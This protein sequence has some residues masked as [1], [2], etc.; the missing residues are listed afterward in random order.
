MLQPLSDAFG[1]VLMSNNAKAVCK[2]LLQFK[3]A[4][5]HSLFSL[6]PS[7]FFGILGGVVMMLFVI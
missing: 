5:T 7:P 4:N 3:R 2:A 1:G 6:D